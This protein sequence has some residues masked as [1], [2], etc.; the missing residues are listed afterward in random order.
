MIY[1]VEYGM[2]ETKAVLLFMCL[3]L[4]TVHGMIDPRNS[5]MPFSD[6]RELLPRK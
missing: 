1:R 4:E 5:M 3:F 6:V 2:G